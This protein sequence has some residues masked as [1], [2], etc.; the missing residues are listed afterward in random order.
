MKKKTSN[1]SVPVPHWHISSTGSDIKY[2]TQDIFSVCNELCLP[3]FKE[4]IFYKTERRSSPS[5]VGGPGSEPR[6][7]FGLL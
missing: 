2:K 4:I 6:S 3:T 7:T 1:Y 5:H